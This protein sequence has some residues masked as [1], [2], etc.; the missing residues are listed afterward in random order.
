VFG[1]QNW[2]KIIY[3]KYKKLNKFNKKT[4][5]LSFIFRIIA[6][7]LS[8]NFSTNLLQ[9]AKIE[10]NSSTLSY[11]RCVAPTLYFASSTAPIIHFS[12]FS[13]HSL[14]EF[15]FFYYVLI[16]KKNS[17]ASLNV[18]YFALLFIRYENWVNV[19]T[20]LTEKWFNLILGKKFVQNFKKC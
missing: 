8:D 18:C 15:F 14:L 6:E 11:Y 13:L 7:M 3:S 19:S 16:E 5:V 9:L 12:T 10:L 4:W 2:I 1:V 17:K 20:T